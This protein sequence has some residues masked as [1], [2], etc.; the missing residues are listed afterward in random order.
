MTIC[1]FN[2]DR[3]IAL[4]MLDR[5]NF[6]KFVDYKEDIREEDIKEEQWPH[7]CVRR[8]TV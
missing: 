6:R 7:K 1:Y 3:S 2:V 5:S 8:N 4:V